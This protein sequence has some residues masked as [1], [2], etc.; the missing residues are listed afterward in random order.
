MT[1]DLEAQNV[2]TKAND[3]VKA[4]ENHTT[5]LF[6]PYLMAELADLCKAL[7]SEFDRVSY[8]DLSQNFQPPC[9]VA[10]KFAIRFSDPKKR[11]SKHVKYWR[12]NNQFVNNIR[13]SR[14]LS[15]LVYLCGG[16]RRHNDDVQFLFLTAELHL[17]DWKNKEIMNSYL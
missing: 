11:F 17:R 12:K 6:P 10:I 1:D 15:S 8:S 4:I 14:A 7:S 2:D 3:I 5:C 13:F 9:Q 16:D